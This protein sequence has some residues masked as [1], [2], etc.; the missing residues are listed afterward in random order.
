MN[1]RELRLKKGLSMRKVKDLTGISPTTVCLWENG[2]RNLPIKKAF[3]LASIYDVSAM[4]IIAA[5]NNVNYGELQKLI[6]Q[7]AKN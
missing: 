2:K 7:A 5:A 4:E 1:L 6:K 3:M